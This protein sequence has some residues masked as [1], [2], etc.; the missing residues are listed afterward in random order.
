M[1]DILKVQRWWLDSL[2][3]EF[4]PRVWDVGAN[5]GRFTEEVFE[6]WPHA[7]VTCFE[8]NPFAEPVD[9]TTWNNVA[10]GAENGDTSFF[11][12]G[13]TDL[14]GSLHHRSII[15]PRRYEPKIQMRRLDSFWKRKVD[16][17]K[18]DIEGAEFEAL[19]GLGDAL[20]PYRVSKIQFEFN[21]CSTE[22]NVGIGAFWALLISRGYRLFELT[23]HSEG[24]YCKEVESPLADF[25]GH[26][27]MLAV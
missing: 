8:A 5:R 20:T 10:V 19:C 21:D 18:L 26:H 11:V 1:E 22:R 3:F 15:G 9:N 7:E 14:T 17:L 13:P 2:D 12:D 6:R 16:I 4:P 24:L 23:E 27:E 25:P